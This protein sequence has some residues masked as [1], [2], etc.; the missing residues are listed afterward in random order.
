M[1]QARKTISPDG[2]KT[3]GQAPDKTQGDVTTAQGEEEV[4]QPDESGS[5][6]QPPP[7]KSGTDV[8]SVN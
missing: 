6:S 3:S 7:A 1:Q 5:P 8:R 4:P 2:E